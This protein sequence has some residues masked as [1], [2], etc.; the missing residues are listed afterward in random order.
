MNFI[1]TLPRTRR[2]NDAFMVIVDKFS[3][4]AQ[5]IACHKTDDAKHIANL[6]FSE[7][8]KLHGIPRSI[9]SDKDSKFYDTFWNTLWKL[10]GTKLRFSILYHPQTGGKIVVTNKTL[11]SI[12]RTLVQKNIKD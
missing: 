5:F 8:I 1:V 9:V 10:I 4:I 6:Y 7:I 2:G 12:L 3:K 11:G